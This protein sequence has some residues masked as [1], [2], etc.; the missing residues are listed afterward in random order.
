[1]K[2]KIDAKTIG[3]VVVLFLICQQMMKKESMC[4]MCGGA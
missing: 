2:M 4:G 3:A 1:M